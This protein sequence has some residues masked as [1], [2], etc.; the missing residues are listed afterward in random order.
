MPYYNASGNLIGSFQRSY[1]YDRLCVTDHAINVHL[2]SFGRP[3][4]PLDD[5][6]FLV[7]QLHLLLLLLFFFFGF[8]DVPTTPVFVF[9]IFMPSNLVVQIQYIYIYIYIYII[10]FINHNK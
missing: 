6:N 3:M 5:G 8:C 2:G 1:L 10:E 4:V 7:H 9:D